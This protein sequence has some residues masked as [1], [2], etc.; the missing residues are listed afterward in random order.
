MIKLDDKDKRLLIE[1]CENQ[2]KYLEEIPKK[3]EN[4]VL[5]IALEANMDILRELACRLGHGHPADPAYITEKTCK[6]IRELKD[7]NIPVKCRE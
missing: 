1:L 7:I 2:D 4:R 6:M 3:L 5:G